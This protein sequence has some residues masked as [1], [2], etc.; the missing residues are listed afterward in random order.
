MAMAFFSVNR[1]PVERIRSRGGP[2]TYSMA[3]KWRPSTSPA[4]MPRTTLGWERR[5]EAL[6]SLRNRAMNL[7]FFEMW[8]W[9]I[10]RAMMLPM[11]RW[12]AR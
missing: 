11:A 8:G 4:S 3:K 6:A 7:G 10:F 1:P 12:R 9:R 5:P 2:S